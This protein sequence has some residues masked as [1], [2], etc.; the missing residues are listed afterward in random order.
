MADVCDSGTRLHEMAKFPKDADTVRKG[1]EHMWMVTVNA[2]K[3]KRIG[4]FKGGCKALIT[5]LQV[6]RHASPGCRVH[7]HAHGINLHPV[8][9]NVCMYVCISL[10][11]YMLMCF[12][13]HKYICLE[14]NLGR[15]S[16]FDRIIGRTSR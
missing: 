15:P 13:L 6:R 1:M 10:R 8:V 3:Q 2:E 14:L 12:C 7:K 9:F 5:A 11:I 4:S 16:R